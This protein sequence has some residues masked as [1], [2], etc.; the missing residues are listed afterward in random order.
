MLPQC[1]SEDL[2]IKQILI[3]LKL[4]GVAGAK[5][6]ILHFLQ[7]PGWCQSTGP[8][9]YLWQSLTWFL[10]EISG[11]NYIPLLSQMK[12]WDL[13]LFRFYQLEAGRATAS[14]PW[15]QINHN[16]PKVKFCRLALAFRWS[17]NYANIPAYFSFGSLF[18][19]WLIPSNSHHSKN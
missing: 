5:G 18:L 15:N 6:K 4:A 2:V 16:R 7:A 14:C 17:D 19:T 10:F 13:K 1:F 12:V 3:Q 9:T 8:Q 11:K